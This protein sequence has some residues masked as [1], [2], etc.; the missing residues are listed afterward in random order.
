MLDM[1]TKV[2]K[3]DPSKPG[4]KA[5][6]VQT[7]GPL[8]RYVIYAIHT[9]EAIQWFVCDAE[10]DDEGYPAVIRQSATMQEALNAPGRFPA[11]RKGP[12]AFDAGEG[13]HTQR[14]KRGFKMDAVIKDGKLIITLDL[15]DPRPSASGKTLV[16]ASSQGNKA[17]T[18]QV[19][20][21]AVVVG[22]NAYIQR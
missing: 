16:V 14:V 13:A 22:V 17:T 6:K 2:E 3:N 20:G 21:K 1:N 7:F 15:Q 8:H 4:H 12:Q 11:Y 9:R 18:A 10:T 19:Q 5:S